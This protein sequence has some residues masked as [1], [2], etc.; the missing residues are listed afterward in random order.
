MATIWK[1]ITNTSS[2][3]TIRQQCT[4]LRTRAW[5]ESWQRFLYLITPR[6]DAA[7]AEL[8]EFR[9]N[10]K[11][12]SMEDKRM[13]GSCMVT[14]GF[15]SQLLLFH[16]KS[17]SAV[18]FR[19]LGHPEDHPNQWVIGFAQNP[20]NPTLTGIFRAG[21]RQIVL[22][23]QGLAWIDAEATQVL[24]LWT[25]LLAPREDVDLA[26]HTTEITY[27]GVRFSSDSDQIIWLPKEVRVTIQ[28]N[29]WEFTNRHRYGNYRLFSVEAKDGEKR[30]LK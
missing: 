6:Q 12:E 4:N 18:A 30:I 25:D 23:V 2:E 20:Q 27:T 8:E 10:R 3:E 16:P 26:R 14:S 1:N 22:L 24:R 17:R 19:L 21:D 11:G 29:Q 15:V 5:H 28:W 7:G 9:S 13:E